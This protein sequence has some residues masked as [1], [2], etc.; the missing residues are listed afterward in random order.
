MSRP[1]YDIA[2][3]IASGVA[4]ETLCLDNLTANVIPEPATLLLLG[5]GGLGFY[6]RIKR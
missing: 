5:L 6:R 3:I 2:Y 1:S 4:G